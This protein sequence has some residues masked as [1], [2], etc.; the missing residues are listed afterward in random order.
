MQAI[1]DIAPSEIR[2]TVTN[3]QDNPADITQGLSAL[4]FQPTGKG[5][6]P[7]QPKLASSSSSEIYI[8]KKGVYT[9]PVPLVPTDWALKTSGNPGGL[10]FALCTLCDGPDELL[11]GGPGADGNYHANRSIEGNEPHNPFLYRTATFTITGIQNVTSINRVLFSFGTSPGQDVYGYSYV[12]V[13][14]PSSLLLIA[15]G[16][17]M[18][19]LTRVYG[20]RAKR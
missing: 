17:L 14:E 7:V 19:G 16:V 5:M 12:P 20:R 18:I 15:A 4:A 3:L 8:D 11:L 2:I 6:M 10:S 13:P 9:A 1:F